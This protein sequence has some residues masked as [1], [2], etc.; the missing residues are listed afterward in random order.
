MLDYLAACFVMGLGIALDVVVATIGR[1]RRYATVAAGRGWLVR[2][3]GTHIA[4]PMVGYYGFV[5]L[6]RSWPALQPVLG[7]I[8]ALLVAVFLVIEF[9]EWI[10]EEGISRHDQSKE[11]EKS[12]WLAVLVVSWDA[13]LSGPAK[14]AQAISWSGA[15]VF[16]SFFVAGAAVTVIGYISLV[17]AVALN[18]SWQRVPFD[19]HRVAVREVIGRWIE[20]SVIG[21]F[22]LL[23]I[24]RYMLEWDLS[25]LLVLS[26]AFTLSIIPFSLFWRRLN[27]VYF[28]RLLLD[29]KCE[30]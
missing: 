13:L 9:R 28:A 24:V 3:T 15:E 2:I 8:A 1:F 25:W 29:T 16:I 18:K 21:Y 19:L 10:S 11:G 6:Y 20:F 14:S 30:D 5:G 12:V 4:F 26:F 7:A 23:A 22:G 17:I 27:R